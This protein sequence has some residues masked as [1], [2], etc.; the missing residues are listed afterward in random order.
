[1]APSSQMFSQGGILSRD[2]FSDRLKS[3]EKVE[4]VFSLFE[5]MLSVRPCSC[6]PVQSVAHLDGDEH[7]QRH[8]HWVGRL[9]HLAV[10]AFKVWVVWTTLEEV[11]LRKKTRA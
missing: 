4:S 3:G 6:S 9:E 11:A 7:R 5:N 8:G 2:W 10:Q 1:M